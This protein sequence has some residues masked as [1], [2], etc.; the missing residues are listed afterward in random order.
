MDWAKN[1]K[2]FHQ[3]TLRMFL[4]QMSIVNLPFNEKVNNLIGFRACHQILGNDTSIYFLFDKWLEDTLLSSKYPRLFSFALVK[5]MR[6]LDAWI[7]R[8]C[9][10]IFKANLYSREESDYE[11]ISNSLSSIALI[12][13]KED[14]LVWNMNLKGF[15]Q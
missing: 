9:S 6:A 10:I 4:V 2:F 8:V 12:L 15:S 13:N 11:G 3:L 5:D 14:G 7:N 1:T